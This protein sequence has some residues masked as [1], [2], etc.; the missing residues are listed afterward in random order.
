MRFTGN[1]ITNCYPDQVEDFIS[2][3]VLRIRLDRRTM[4]TSY[5]L[6]VE[7]ETTE[8]GVNAQGEIG[9]EYR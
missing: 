3:T 7:S 6:E 9:A 1:G 8:C 4:P 5:A 2:I